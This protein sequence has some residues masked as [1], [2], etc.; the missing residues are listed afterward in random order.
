MRYIGLILGN[1]SQECFYNWV[2][3]RILYFL[4]ALSVLLA[5]AATAQPRLK[6]RSDRF[7]LGKVPK[8]TSVSHSFLFR[9]IGSDTLIID[10]I[11]TGC[12]CT[13][14]GLERN[15][16]AP[17]DSMWVSVC[18]DTGKKRGPTGSYPYVFTNDPDSPARLFLT[19]TIVGNAAENFPTAFQPHAFDLSRFGDKSVDSISFVVRN[20]SA[21]DYNIRPVSFFAEECEIILPESVKANSTASGYVKV[22]KEFLDKEFKGSIT[23]EFD[24]KDKTRITVPIRRRIY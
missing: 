6:I 4:T 19:G 15:R 1:K 17:G 16:L 12:G 8:E 21:D 23:V 14:A 10:E 7:E 24:D 3:M 2:S 22:K 5:G 20:K 9:S 18:W 13:L 11:K